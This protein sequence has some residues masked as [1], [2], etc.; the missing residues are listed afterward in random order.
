MAPDLPIPAPTTWRQLR[1]TDAPVLRNDLWDASRSIPRGVWSVAV[2]SGTSAP[3]LL[4]I[5]DY[6]VDDFGSLAELAPAASLANDAWHASGYTI[7]QAACEWMDQF[8]APLRA[9]SAL[10]AMARQVRQQ[11]PM[12][13]AVGAPGAHVLAEPRSAWYAASVSVDD[14]L[15]WTP[16]QPLVSVEV[17]HDEPQ[18]LVLTSTQARA[19]G[20]V[21]LSLVLTACGG[22]GDD[23]DVMTP[24]V[25][26]RVEVCR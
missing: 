1:P 22:G 8:T 7:D 12:A 10:Q 16:G 2:Y 25:D 9:G 24:R 4:A 20:A 11:Q 26:C 23:P 13:W 3:K 14:D 18:R 19:L 21:L 17:E 6:A 15:H 5:Q